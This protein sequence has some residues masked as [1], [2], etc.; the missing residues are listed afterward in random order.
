MTFQLDTCCNL[1]L[2]PGAISVPTPDPRG[3]VVLKLHDGKGWSGEE[4]EE[5]EEDKED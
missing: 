3:T 2:G 4:E 1:I 5:E